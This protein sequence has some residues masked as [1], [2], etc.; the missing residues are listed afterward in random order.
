MNR[1]AAECLSQVE[2]WLALLR[3]TR[4]QVECFALPMSVILR[5]VDV[6]ILRRC[7]Y[8]GASPPESFEELWAECAIRDGVCAEWMRD[9][10][11]EF[12]KSYREEQ[13][14]GC[15]YYETLLEQRR[16]AL[17]SELP[18]KKKIHSALW[19]SGA[20]AVVILLI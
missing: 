9:F 1:S 7:G 6:G 19:V 18:A 5:R 4:M 8:G 12:G 14:R 16:D 15:E 13:G 11:R 10:S 17:I 2:G 3:Y 20:L